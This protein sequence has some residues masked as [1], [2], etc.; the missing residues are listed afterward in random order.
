MP[1]SESLAERV[2]RML[3]DRPDIAEQR[4]FGGV[5]FLLGGNMC[6]AIWKT[7][8]IARLGPEQA[9][10]ALQEPHVGEFDVTGRPM[11]GWVMIAADGLDT[12]RELSGWIEQAV[13]FVEELPRKSALVKKARVQGKQAARRR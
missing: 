2:R 4:M 10:A 13:A 11:R 1:Y 3:A 6:V 5:G 9:A 8:L 7:S 12:D